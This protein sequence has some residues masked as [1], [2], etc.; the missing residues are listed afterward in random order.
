V[1]ALVRWPRG[2]QGAITPAEFIPVAEEAGLIAPLGDY[3]L[4]H[5]CA[6]AMA[7]PEHMTL[8]VNMSPLQFRVGNVLDAVLGALKQS[9]LPP[10]RL[11]V[12]ITETLFL[13]KSEHVLSTLHALRSKGVRIAMDDFGTGYSSLSYLRSFPFD[14]IKI[15]RSFVREIYAN[16]E[17][18][19]IVRAIMSLGSSLGMTITAEGIESEAELAFLKAVGCDQ[20]QGYL[21]SKAVPQAELLALLADER[22]RRVA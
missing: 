2:A 3:V 7:W 4:R 18:Q 17:Q 15:D 6:D 20:A 19:A 16:V 8:A 12:E 5:A 11:E 13:E 1:E 21:F 9:G 10:E 14:K 22:A